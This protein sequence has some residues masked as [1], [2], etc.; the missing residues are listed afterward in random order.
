M[1]TLWSAKRSH[2]VFVSFILEAGGRSCADINKKTHRSNNLWSASQEIPNM[3]KG[4]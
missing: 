1:L 2:A 4:I 3:D